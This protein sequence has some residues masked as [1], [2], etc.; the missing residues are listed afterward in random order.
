M[1][2]NDWERLKEKYSH[3]NEVDLRDN[4]YDQIIHLTTA[5]NGA[6]QFYNLDNNHTRT[7]SIE[8]AREIDERLAKAWCGHPYMDVIDNCTEFDKKVARVLQSV[9]ERIGLNFKGYDASNKKRKFLLKS[10]PDASVRQLKYL[11]NLN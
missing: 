10:L 1:P 9:C 8:L 4:R 3:W 7:E 11:V 2:E 6:E 5:A